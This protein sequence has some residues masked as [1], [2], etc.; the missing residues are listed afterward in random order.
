MDPTGFF[1]SAHIVSPWADGTPFMAL[2]QGPDPVTRVSPPCCPFCGNPSRDYNAEEQ[3]RRHVNA[4]L[5]EAYLHVAVPLL[6]VS[7]QIPCSKKIEV[8]WARPGTE[9]TQMFEA[10]VMALIR[11]IPV[12]VAAAILKTGDQRLWR[13]VERGVGREV[14]WGEVAGSPVLERRSGRKGREFLNL[15]YDLDITF[16]IS[17]QAGVSAGTCAERPPVPKE[18]V[19]GP[20][21][22]HFELAKAAILAALI[23]RAWAAL[24][25]EIFRVIKHRNDALGKVSAEEGMLSPSKSRAPPGVV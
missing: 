17:D 2:P 3:Q 20:V 6:P 25:L 7:K 13:I 4:L 1:L 15:F 9:F 14:A 5:S 12:K 11:R 8:P 16:D 24:A 21:A 22:A 18:N 19:P 23:T 10:L